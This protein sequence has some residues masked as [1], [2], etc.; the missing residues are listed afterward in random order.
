[1]SEQTVNDSRSRSNRRARWIAGVVL[2]VFLVSGCGVVAAYGISASDRPAP[3][4]PITSATAPIERGT[5][6]GSSKASGSLAFADPHDL[7]SGSAGVVTA[8][9]QPGS[10]VGI[11]QPLFS[12]DNVPVYLFHGDLPAWRAFASGMDD[13][14]DVKQLE[15]NLKALGYF[16]AEPDDE[17]SWRTVSAIKAWQKATG[18]EQTGGVDLGRVVF[19]HGDV[20]VSALKVAVGDSAAPGAPVL[21]VTGTEKRVSVNL[22]LADQRLAK[23]GGKVTIDLPGGTQTGGT[24]TSVGTPQENKDGTGGTSVSIPVVIT[25]DDPA[26]AGEL[27]QATVTVNFPSDT[28]ENVL[29]VPVGALVALSGSQFGVEVVK[30][31]GTTTRVAVKTGLF[32]GGRVEISGGGLTEGQK[33][34]VPAL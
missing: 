25:L 9:P 2:A 23:A 19:Q 22:R 15:Q 16:A 24:V 6:T 10:T 28:R 33:V 4:R 26:A 27:Q 12:V 21:S 32:A 13:G 30:K 34:V 18:Q 8:L 20:R 29:S 1:M 17:F 5:L 7:G 3:K 11:G 14:P 31:D